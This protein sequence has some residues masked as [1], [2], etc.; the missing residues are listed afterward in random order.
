MKIKVIVAC[1]E[2]YLIGAK[3]K[4]PWSVKDE[5][6]HF[7]RTTTGHVVVM[8]YNTYESLNMPILPKRENVVI[9]S[10][11]QRRLEEFKSKYPNATVGPMFAASLDEAIRFSQFV[12]PKKDVFII[13]GASIYKMAFASGIIDEVLLSQIHEEGKTYSGDAYFMT[14][15]ELIC[16]SEQFNLTSTEEYPDW[17]LFTYVKKP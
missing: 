6:A 3:G 4:L 13:G 12:H 15:A 7:K 11:P 10:D 9:T 1:D 17:S 5:M 14:L 16:F 8:G 2:N